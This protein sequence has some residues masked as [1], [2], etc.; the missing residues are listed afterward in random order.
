[1]SLLPDSASSAVKLHKVGNLLA[2]LPGAYVDTVLVATQMINAVSMRTTRPPI[3][4][5]RRRT[6][7]SR[8][9]P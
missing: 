9:T 2:V 4:H 8:P 6:Q 5:G 3:D 1:V 7:N